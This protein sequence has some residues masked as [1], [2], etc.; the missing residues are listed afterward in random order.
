MCPMRTLYPPQT[1]R[2]EI[3]AGARE[4]LARRRRLVSADAARESFAEFCRQAIVAGEVEGI[5]RVEWGRHLELHCWE[6]QMQLE[7]WLVANGHGTEE[8]VQRQRGA[9]ERTGATWEDGDS[10]PWLRYVLVQNA[11]DNLPPGTLK[12]TIVMVLALPWI[13]LWCATFSMGA[14]SG[15][16]ANVGR[17]SRACRELV[18]S[19]WYRETFGISWTDCT[20]DDP[21]DPGDALDLT[22]K[23]DADAVEAW[24][25]SAG[26]KRIS[27]TITRGLTGAHVDGI[28]LDDPDDADRVYSEPDRLRPQNRWAR[29]VETRVNSDHSS[30]RRVL[31]Q[32][33]HPEGFTTYVLS[34]ARWSPA[35]PKG[36]SLFCLP[37]EFGFGPDDAPAETPYGTRD[38]RS[39]KGETLHSRLSP[40]V[41]ADRKLKIPGYEYQFNQRRD[42]LTGGDF[43][44]RFAKFFIFEG[45]RMP[46]RA[47]PLMCV[48]RL[49]CPPLIVKQSSLDRWTLS[50]DAANSIDP[51]P[52]G[53]TSAVG[54]IVGATRADDRFIVDDRTRVLGASATYLAIYEAIV[55][56]PIACVLVE[57]KAMGPSVIAEIRL[58]IQRGWY[59]HPTSSERI[60]L[61]GPDGRRPRCEV[62]AFKPGKDSKEQRWQGMLPDWQ[63]GRIY[64]HDGADWLDPTVDENRRT[65]D[66]GFVG[67]ISALPKSRRTD[68]ADA[69]AQF[70]AKYRGP[71]VSRPS[72]SGWVVPIAR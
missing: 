68:R 58:T 32:V 60:D 47:R 44:R 19:A 25:T 46:T 16:D 61:L 24:A 27:R 59:I 51:D 72:Y 67:E 14:L 37:A 5:T 45:E 63:G 31:Q 13:W 15:I 57:L 28:F 50:V 30:I 70:I 35:R 12:S 36:W 1:A 69:T 22:I 6:V 3:A 7:S 10:D 40:G 71:P 48:T 41:L 66:E 53:K 2:T 65:L 54:L 62:E 43:E 29:V 18:R 20:I 38:W 39:L 23:R 55:A 42:T 17:D 56:W 8:M 11:I 33:T 4:A 52:K 21:L 34:I 26:G 49:D 64:M 9:W